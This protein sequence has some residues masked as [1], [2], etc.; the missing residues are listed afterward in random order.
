MDLHLSS[1]GYIEGTI[2]NYKVYVLNMNCFKKDNEKHVIDM[3]DINSF[4]KPETLVKVMVGCGYP[5][6]VVA[7]V[8]VTG[9]SWLWDV[10]E[11]SEY[12]CP[13]N[14]FLQD[15]QTWWYIN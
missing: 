11:D 2:E 1:N 8:G 15:G 4:P 13:C 10:K 7:K 14:E 12:G 5:R 9:I 6:E 3:K